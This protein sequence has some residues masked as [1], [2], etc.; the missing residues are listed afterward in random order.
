MKK[1]TVFVGMSGGVDS[2]VAAL[3]L[4][5]Q[6]YAVVGVFIKVWQPDF[7]SCHWEAERLDAMRVAA[8]LDIPFLTCDAEDTYKKDVADYFIESYKTG[9][10]PN[11]DVMCNTH[12]KFGRFFEFAKEHNA[13]HIAT[14]HYA[15]TKSDTIP[16]QL[17]RGADVVK[18]QSYF[19]WNIS[20]DALRHTLF[21]I[22]HLQK[23]EVR[24]IATRANLPTATKDE[25]QGICFLGHVDMREFLSHYIDL[26]DGVVVDEQG[27]SIG[28][29][30]G[31]VLYTIGQRHGFHI[32]PKHAS[33][34]PYFVIN[35]DKAQNTIMVSTH[36]PQRRDLELTLTNLRYYADSTSLPKTLDVQIRY[37][38]KPLQARVTG[39]TA[40]TLSLTFTEPADIP[41]QGQSCVLYSNDR[42]LAGGIISASVLH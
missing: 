11:P 17:L 42:V 38:Q 16:A 7:L 35:K 8:H 14:G 37:R 41:D 5:E 34:A 26:K 6:G 20:E 33:T 3:L 15:R 18:D 23:S 39:T 24:A 21:P 22:G 19:L 36:K 13:T 10:T 31:A 40:S 29:H 4:K 32:D 30:H 27:A 12:I 28:S 1:Q 9:I 2:S 25:S